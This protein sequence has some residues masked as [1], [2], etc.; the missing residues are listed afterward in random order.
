M[1]KL[2]TFLKTFDIEPHDISLYQAAFTHSSC[3]VKGDVK[4]YE[5]LE[6]LG[7]ALIN[8]YVAYLIFKHRPNL[9]EG[10]MTLMRSEI[11]QTRSLAKIGKKLGL[12]ELIIFG[13]SINPKEALQNERFYEDVLE[14][15]VGAL[16]LDAGPIKSKEIMSVI[17]SPIVKSH[18]IKKT[19]NY[20]NALQEAIQAE[21]RETVHYVSTKHTSPN[22][23][24][25]FEAEVFLEDIKLGRGIGKTK[26]AAE[27]EAAKDALEK[28]AS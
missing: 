17:F 21:R 5:R 23:E 10:D 25:Y 27:Q 26:K 20:K 24:Q 7:D 16:Y 11:V 14:A 13:D 22:N 2:I 18:D 19:T 6:F 8:S 1:N 15:F 28:K 9:T 12:G 3:N 4:S